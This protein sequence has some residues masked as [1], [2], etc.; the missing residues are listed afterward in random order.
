VIPTAQADGSVGL[1]VR[2]FEA[3]A[4]ADALP[5]T[6]FNVATPLD[7]SVEAREGGA[8][9]TVAVTRRPELEPPATTKPAA[10]AKSWDP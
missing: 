9:L 6:E 8:T 2:L 3:T 4:S 7:S 10:A 5:I 1:R